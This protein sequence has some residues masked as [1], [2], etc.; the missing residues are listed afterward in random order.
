MKVYQLGIVGESN[1]QD[2]ICQCIEGER[3][4]VCHEPDNPY[5]DLALKVETAGGRTIGYV[6]KSSWLRRAIHDE[7]RGVTC[8]IRSLG[9]GDGDI[10]GVVL[11]VTLTDDDIRER[12]Y[13]D[14]P[15]APTPPPPPAEPKGNTALADFLKSIFK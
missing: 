7:G 8:T 11:D 4:Y 1:Y 5:D 14:S 9:R 3:V 15:A 13:G 2:A 10:V 12:A 6:A